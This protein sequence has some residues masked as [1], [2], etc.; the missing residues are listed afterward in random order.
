MAGTLT[1]KFSVTVISGCDSTVG[2]LVHFTC[3]FRGSCDPGSPAAEQ[4]LG[5]I[6]R[7]AMDDIVHGLAVVSIRYHRVMVVMTLI[8]HGQSPQSSSRVQSPG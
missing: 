2:G 5:S 6:L 7:L 3:V 1:S 4:E 8:V